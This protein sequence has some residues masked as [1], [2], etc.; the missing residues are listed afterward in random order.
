MIS[1]FDKTEKIPSVGE[2]TQ[3]ALTRLGIHQIKDLLLHVPSKVTEKLLNPNL[4]SLK[5]GEYIAAKV[6]IEN[7]AP[8]P[9]F[10]RRNPYKIICSNETGFITLIFFN[11][12]PQYLLNSHNIGQEKII[13]GK[14]EIYNGIVTIA[15]PEIHNFESEDLSSKIVTYPLTYGIVSRQL[16]KYV[17]FALSKL[18]M[19]EWFSGKFLEKHGWPS[20]KKALSEI[21]NGDFIDRENDLNFERLTFDELLAGQISLTQLRNSKKECHGNKVNFSGDL[22][23]K[24]LNKLGFELTNAQKNVLTEICC[25]QRSPNQ[26]S[27]LLQGDVG[28][29]K[30]LVALIFCLNSIEAAFQSAIMAPTDI[31]ANQHYDFINGVFGDEI[32]VELLTGKIKGKKRQELL[33]KLSNHEIDLLIGTHA[34]FQENV[35]FKKLAAVVIDE[36]HRFGV[37]QRQM[38]SSKGNHPDILSM[39]ATPIPRTLTMTLYGDMDV[40]I[41]NEKP[42]GR[43]AIVT[44]VMPISKADEIIDSIHKLVENG[45]KIYWICPLIE[46]PENDDDQSVAKE[47]LAAAKERFAILDKAFKNDSGESI[48]GL[49]HGKM[50][51]DEKNKTMNNFQSGAKKILV[52][53]TVIEVGVN[54]PD[55]TIIIIE[56]AERFGLAQLHQL[57]GRVGRGDKDSKCLL[58]YGLKISKVGKERLKIMKESEDGFYLAEKDLELRGGGDIL[59]TKQ[60]G[61][62]SFKI[63]D[64]VNNFRKSHNLLVKAKKLA[65]EII[66][67]DPG[68]QGPAKNFRNLLRI[69]N[70]DHEGIAKN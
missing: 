3:E 13:S 46:E 43:K 25:D 30:T 27:R 42:P 15:H 48:V 64:F 10:S 8:P 29:G 56:Q 9:K 34:L 70:K 12:R 66:A 57:R 6:T 11:Y 32:R 33:T 67:I 54:V 4:R 53:T 31:L 26:M 44:N 24:L 28:S 58:L 21:H 52:A 41:L 14:V 35:V 22:S 23:K 2:K 40:S 17:N 37:N 5:G 60:S 65:Q 16:T 38:L 61:L 62:A 7:I 49:V 51:A 68:L 1:I 20:F 45:E 47:D 36:Q 50:K 59:G 69:F 19:P 63:A 55:A 39:S 18:E